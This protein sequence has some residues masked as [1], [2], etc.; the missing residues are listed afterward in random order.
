MKF[1]PDLSLC[2]Q[3]VTLYRRRGDLI[4]REVVEHASFIYGVQQVKDH[5]GTRRETVFQLIIPGNGDLQPGDRVYGGIGPETVDWNTFL[6]VTV[7]GLAEVEYAK[8]YHLSD[9][10]CHTLAGRR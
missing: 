9:W 2:N 8:V 7:S 10:H 3:V 5:L 1:L 4:T 6:P